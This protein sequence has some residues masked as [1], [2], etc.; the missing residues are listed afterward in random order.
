M[1]AEYINP[2]LEAANLVFNDLLKEKLIR[3]KTQITPKFLPNKNQD[4]AI[5][6]QLDGSIEGKVIYAFPE[7]TAK[8]IFERLM[9]TLNE[10]IFKSEYK[11]VLGEIGNMI[12]GNAMNIFLNKKQFIEVSVPEVIDLKE[13]NFPIDNNITIRLNMYSKLG[14]MEIDVS[15]REKNPKF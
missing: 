2:F 15:I 10:E 6:I 8:K 4:I 13:K 11:D 5:L 3:G 14:M 7:F 9:G 1:K 12:T